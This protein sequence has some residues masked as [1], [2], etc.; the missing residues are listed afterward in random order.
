[1]TKIA[2]PAA[3]LDDVI[4]TAYAESFTSLLFHPS[5]DDIE[6]SKTAVV[7]QVALDVPE[8][9]AA[10]LRAHEVVVGPVKRFTDR[11]RGEITGRQVKVNVVVDSLADGPEDGWRRLRIAIVDQAKQPA[12]FA[13]LEQERPKPR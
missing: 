3:D 6:L 10:I 8:V 4:D 11:L 5:A 9:T 13:E 7:I 1:M 2:K 12:L